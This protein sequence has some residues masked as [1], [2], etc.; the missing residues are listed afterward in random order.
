MTKTM[1]KLGIEGIYLDLI[2]SIYENP[3]TDIILNGKKF[4]TFSSNI[5]K[6][7]RMLTLITLIKHSTGIP[8]HKYPVRKRNR[9]QSYQ[10]ERNKI[11]SV[12][13]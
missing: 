13:K 11:I 5:R 2:K 6:K 4:K 12:C 8:S 10:K 9:S 7:E 1:D 3:K